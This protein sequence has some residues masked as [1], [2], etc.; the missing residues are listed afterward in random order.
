[1]NEAIIAKAKELGDLIANSP[2]KVRT[3]AANKALLED[4]E[5]SQLINEYNEKR[6]AKIAPFET[7]QPTE[8]EMKEISDYLQAEFA[9]MAENATIQEYIEAAHVYEMLI[10]QTDN[11]LKASINGQE[12]HDCGGSCSTCGGC[13]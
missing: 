7:K 1:M 6:Q 5:A 10:G 12:D 9:K 8:E 2:E 13:N 11:I 4:A 3:D